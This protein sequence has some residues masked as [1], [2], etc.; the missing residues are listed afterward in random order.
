MINLSFI[1]F[2]VMQF[3]QVAEESRA[4]SNVEKSANEHLNMLDFKLT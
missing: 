2:N 4:F 1:V 3:P